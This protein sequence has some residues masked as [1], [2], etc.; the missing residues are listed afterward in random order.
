[1]ILSTRGLITEALTERGWPLNGTIVDDLGGG[2]SATMVSGGTVSCR[3]DTLTGREGLV[4]NRISDRSTHLI[5]LAPGNAVTT[6][7]DFQ[8]EDRGVFEVTAVREHTGEFST[9]FEAVERT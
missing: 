5:T 6:D 9:L 1:M 7:S 2:G 3:I 8:I 4:A